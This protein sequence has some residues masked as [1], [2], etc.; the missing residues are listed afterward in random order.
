[1]DEKLTDPDHL[2]TWIYIQENLST[3]SECSD[4]LNFCL[5]FL[6]R[7]RIIKSFCIENIWEIQMSLR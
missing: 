7:I 2:A 4:L 3:K 6:L 1:M 5:S